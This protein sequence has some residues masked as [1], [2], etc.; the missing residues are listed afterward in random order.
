MKAPVVF[1]YDDSASTYEKLKANSVE[2][3]GE[4]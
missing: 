4:P 2:F 1:P 3:L